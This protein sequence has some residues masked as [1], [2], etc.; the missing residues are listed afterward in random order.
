MSK[1]KKS[2][3]TTSCNVMTRSVAAAAMLIIRTYIWSVLQDRRGQTDL[4][5]LWHMLSCWSTRSRNNP[6]QFL[7]SYNLTVAPPWFTLCI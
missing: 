6:T 2:K 5:L 4:S 3:K 1:K 7:P